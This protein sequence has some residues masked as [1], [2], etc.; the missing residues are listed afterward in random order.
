MTIKEE[1]DDLL[2][3][4]AAEIVPVRNIQPGEITA[5]MLAQRTGLGEKS[6]ANRLN[7]KVT[8]GELVKIRV[9]DVDG[10]IR[11]AYRRKENP[12]IE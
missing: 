1:I 9:R 12:P 3:E 8:K 5:R 11:M 10:T 6:A 7:E 4:L 2:E